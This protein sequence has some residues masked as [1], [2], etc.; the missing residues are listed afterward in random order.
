MFTVQPNTKLVKGAIDVVQ[1]LNPQVFCN[2]EGKHH[3]LVKYPKP[4]TLVQG[5]P[6]DLR[7]KA[8]YVQGQL[9]FTAV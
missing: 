1:H 7:L 6:Y 5:L 2:V 4:E 3:V 8:N 9:T